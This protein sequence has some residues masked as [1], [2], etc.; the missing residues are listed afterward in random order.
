M[1]TGS[2]PPSTHT[3]DTGLQYISGKPET[4]FVM[5]FGL[6]GSESDSASPAM[7][8]MRGLPSQAI[9]PSQ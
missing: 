8:A 9:T 1:K 7:R 5:V 3:W 4:S 6:I 2:L